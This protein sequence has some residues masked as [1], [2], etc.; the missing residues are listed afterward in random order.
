M[1]RT[2]AIALTLL[3]FVVGVVAYAL[4]TPDREPEEPSAARG[5]DGLGAGYWLMK[6]IEETVGLPHREKPYARHAVLARALL[7]AIEAQQA[8]AAREMLSA[9][10]RTETEGDAILEKWNEAVRTLGA[11]DALTQEWRWTT[12]ETGPPDDAGEQAQVYT[13][14]FSRNHARG[15]TV[16]R[17]GVV[18]E[19]GDAVVTTYQLVRRHFRAR[20]R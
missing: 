11:A 19:Q 16:S 5:V 4:G 8:D 20:D 10:L 7:E 9:G 2:T 15:S 12:M 18:L 1:S 13:F 3:V 14:N 6:G 17:V